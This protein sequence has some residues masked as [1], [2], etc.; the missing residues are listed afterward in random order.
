MDTFHHE[1]HVVWDCTYHVVMVPKY[2]KH[3]LYGPIRKRVGEILRELAKQKG[4]EIVR[5]N[6]MPNHIHMM[7]SIPPKYSVARTMGFLKGKSAIR[8]HHE[9]GRRKMLLYTAS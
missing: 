6:A 4:I 3:V 9:F 7:L 8:I 5:G 2:R 1:D